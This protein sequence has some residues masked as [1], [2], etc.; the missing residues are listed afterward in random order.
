LKLTYSERRKRQYAILDNMVIG[1]DITSEDLYDRIQERNV[2]IDIPSGGRLG[3]IIGVSLVEKLH[4]VIRVGTEIRHS[5]G[6][7]PKPY[8]VKVWRRV[9]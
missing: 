4:R 3:V 2:D 5:K 7:T 8:E 6:K 1:E 9:I